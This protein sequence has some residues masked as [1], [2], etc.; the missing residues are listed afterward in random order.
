M[1]DGDYS[2]KVTATASGKDVAP[3]ALV[4]GKVGSISGDSSGVLVDIGRKVYEQRPVDV[5]MGHVNVIWQGDA[6]SVA[7]RA[8]RLCSAPP[9]LLNLTG[10]ETLARATAAQ[11]TTGSGRGPARRRVIPNG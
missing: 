10:P 9:R 7:L 4:Y 6:N 8:F 2:F 1:P 3:V 11:W 5:T